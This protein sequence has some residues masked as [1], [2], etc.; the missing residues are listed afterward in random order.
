M[1]ML[2]EAEGAGMRPCCGRPLKYDN[3]A[4]DGEVE[5]FHGWMEVGLDSLID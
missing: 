2:G 5:H 4:S 3:M 1:M